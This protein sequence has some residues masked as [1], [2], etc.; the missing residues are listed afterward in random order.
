MKS[1]WG[2]WWVNHCWTIDSKKAQLFFS[3]FSSSSSVFAF[4]QN[5]LCDTFTNDGQ[6]FRLDGSNDYN[7]DSRDDGNSSSNILTL[8]SPIISRI[9]FVL[10]FR[11]PII[12]WLFSVHLKWISFSFIL[13]LFFSAFLLFIII[14][15]IL[16]IIAIIILFSPF[17]W[18]FELLL[19]AGWL[20]SKNGQCWTRKRKPRKCWKKSSINENRLISS[21]TAQH[22]CVMRMVKDH[23]DLHHNL[24]F[25]HHHHR[26]SPIFQ[27]IFFILFLIETLFYEKPIQTTFQ[28]LLQL[29]S[30]NCSNS[31]FSATSLFSKYETL[32][33]LKEMDSDR[34]I[35]SFDFINF[36][37]EF[38]VEPELGDEKITHFLASQ[39]TCDLDF[40]SCVHSSCFP[41]LE[42]H[43]QRWKMLKL[44]EK[45]KLNQCF[46][47]H[48]MYQLN[49]NL[50]NL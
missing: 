26:I 24:F 43:L 29:F 46:S 16:I 47:W 31:L 2:H 12:P 19:V 17:T 4:S 50:F 13:L 3:T 22:V 23:F 20:V 40:L 18:L 1:A 7:D 25:H 41:F 28:E 42:L 14:I 35:F 30:F 45:A 49:F 15:L 37:A 11:S 10:W 8:V 44:K 33:P 21:L 38:S 5:F 32:E 36:F 9:G 34:L 48:R 27:L 39:L 6:Q